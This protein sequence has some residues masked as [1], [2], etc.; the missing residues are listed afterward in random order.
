VIA[1]EDRETEEEAKERVK[2]VV[3]NCDM[4][5]LLRMKNAERVKSK[6]IRRS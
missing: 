5:I 1:K 3:D 4:Q 6:C 2:S